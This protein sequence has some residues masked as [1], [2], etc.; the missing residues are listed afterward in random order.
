MLNKLCMPALIYL[1]FIMIHISVDTYYG[2]YNMVMVKIAIGVIGTL[3]LNILCQNNMSV[4]SW[5][6]VSIP[7]VMMS[8]IAVFVLFVLGLNPATGKNIKVTQDPPNSPPSIYANPVAVVAPKMIT[9]AI[10]NTQNQPQLD[11]QTQVDEQMQPQIDINANP[12]YGIL[13]NNVRAVQ[14]N[15]S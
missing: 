4:I 8:V 11:Q 7:F 6:I 14:S 2:L 5:L 1:V 15:Y 3:L 9:T 13:A 10:Q 12:Y